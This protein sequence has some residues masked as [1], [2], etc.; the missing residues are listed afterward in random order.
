VFDSFTRPLKEKVLIPSAS[1]IGRFLSPNQISVIAF[2]SGLL[3]AAAVFKSNM[4]VGIIFWILNRILDGLDGTVA[5]V[6][7]K[8]SDFGGYLDIMLD[9]ILY[10]LIPI[11]F[12]YNGMVIGGSGIELLWACLILFGIFYINLGSWSLLSAL[13]EKKSNNRIKESEGEQLT[14]LVMPTGIIEGTETVVFYTLFFIFP[15]QV[16]WLFLLMSLLT[17]SGAVQ[18]WIWAVKNIK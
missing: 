17:A 14:S 5:R 2:L 12:V 1:F 16:L 4:T 7:G 13:I 8:M 11:A 9:L 6:T 18:R 3:S 15:S 10:I